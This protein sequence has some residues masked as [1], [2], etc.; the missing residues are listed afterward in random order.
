MNTATS[1]Q[2]RFDTVRQATVDLVTSLEQTTAELDLPALP[3][4]LLDSRLNVQANEY[5]VLVV[6]EAK[7]GKSSFVNALIGQPILPVDV[8]VATC[9]VFRIRQAP[10]EGYRLRFEDDTSRPIGREDLVR[11]GSQAFIDRETP[12]PLNE[13]I[14]WV[15]VDVPVRFLPS[16]VNLLDTPGLGSLYAHHAL[17]TH[18]FVPL[19]DGVIFVTDSEK[20]LLQAELDFLNTLLD[21]TSNIFFVQTKIDRFGSSWESIRDRNQEILQQFGERLPDR[22]IWPMSSTNLLKAAEA[23]SEKTA[24]ALMM[25]SRHREMAVA[26][27]AFLIRAAGWDRPARAVML[28]S[29]HHAAAR[30]VLVERIRIM[31]EQSRTERE[32]IQGRIREQQRRFEAD[33]GAKSEPRRKLA[34][35]LKKILSVGESA[36]KQAVQSGGEIERAMKQRINEI[37]SLEAAE[38]FYPTISDEVVLAVTQRWQNTMHLTQ[39]RCVELLKPFLRSVDQSIFET[40]EGSDLAPAGQAVCEKNQLFEDMFWKRFKAARWD[41]TVA[42]SVAGTGITALTLL[43]IISLPVTFTL[44]PLAA[45]GAWIWGWKKGSRQVDKTEL[46]KAKTTMRNHASEV[47]GMLRQQFLNVDLA[48]GSSGLLTETFEGIEEAVLAQVEETA[49]RKLEEAEEEL[50]RLRQQSEQDEAQ[51]QQ[52]AKRASEQLVAWDALGTEIQKI[53]GQLQ[54][55]NRDLET[56]TGSHNPI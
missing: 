20:P 43:S 17:I 54:F 50:Q 27:Q 41:A 4:A 42:T 56:S 46:E 7:R 48:S 44:A 12:P 28:A 36:F 14:R 26:L 3:Q 49:S 9:Q 22:R 5:Q 10:Q 1:I 53:Q 16:G 24:E 6:G 34:A 2:A 30:P 35:D 18:H 31:N 19:A 52:Y 8:E 45:L 29:Q 21:V 15:E 47:L 40:T 39:S 37:T 13:L 25:V 32:A 33:W 38:A 11:Y 55:L 23:S 51:R